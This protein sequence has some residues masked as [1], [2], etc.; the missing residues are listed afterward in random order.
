[1]EVDREDEKGAGI[2]FLG[3]VGFGYTFFENECLL[4]IQRGK[5]DS[6]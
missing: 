2:E 1:M 4:D 3:K 6:I 5:G